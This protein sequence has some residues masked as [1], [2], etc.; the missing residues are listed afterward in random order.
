[1]GRKGQSCRS[2]LVLGRNPD[3][4]T[5]AE[6]LDQQAKPEEALLGNSSPGNR[7]S[8]S[9]EFNN[10]GAGDGHRFAPPGDSGKMQ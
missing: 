4:P 8:S 6:W 5:L 7:D 10:E 1:M 2:P 3:A 9:G